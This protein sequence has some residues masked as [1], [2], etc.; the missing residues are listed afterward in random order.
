MMIVS[1]HRIL[2]VTGGT[3]GLQD[4]LERHDQPRPSQ[5]AVQLW[6]NRNVVPARWAGA[7][8]YACT[9]GL[10]VDPLNL[11]EDKSA[12]TAPIDFDDDEWNPL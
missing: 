7:I 1:I 5:N 2:A 6:K 10:G 8:L 12:I 4:L 11:L 9:V 3:V